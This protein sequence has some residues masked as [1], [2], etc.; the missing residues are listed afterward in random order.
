M[1]GESYSTDCPRCGGLVTLQGYRD[2]KPYD[3]ISATCINC[4]LRIDTI[5]EI[6]TLLEVNEVREEQGLP[7]ILELTKPLKDWLEWGYEPIV[8]KKEA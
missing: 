3:Q 7:P 2:W 1:S 8:I 5:T 4:G 6:A